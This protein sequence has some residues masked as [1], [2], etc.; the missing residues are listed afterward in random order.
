MAAAV[1]TKS[2]GT[3]KWFR[4]DINGLR[5]LAIVPVVAFHAGVPGVPGGFTGVDI[6]Y[7]ISGYL[8]TAILLKEAAATG[9][10]RIGAFW[11]KRFRR[12]APA[13]CLMVVVTL[14][15]ALPV[16]SPMEWADVSKQS[17]ASVLYVSNMLYAWQAADY[18]A[19]D[20][21]QS[22]LLHTWSL[23]VEEQFYVL[24]PALI[25]LACMIARRFGAPLRTLVI[26]AFGA[27]LVASFAASLWM[28]DELPL[29]AFFGLPSRIWEFAA[30]GLVAALPVAKLFE[31][32]RV[33]LA[34]TVAGLG[35][36]VYGFASVTEFDPFP[37]TAALI[38][39]CG[40]LL[41][42]AGGAGSHSNGNIA[43]RA[44]SA[45]PVQWI[46]AVSYS[47]YLWHWP[48]IVLASAAFQ[49]P[50]VWIKLGAGAA[51][52]FV[53][54]LSYRYVE[55]PIRY[56]VRLSS[57]KVRTFA[58]TA[59]AAAGVCLASTTVYVVSPV[60][61]EKAFPTLAA[62][63]GEVLDSDDC[64]AP[65]VSPSGYEY[66]L[67]GDAQGSRSVLVVGDSHAGQWQTA[68]GVAA[69]QSGVRLM[70]RWRSSCPAIPVVVM[71]TRNVR[72]PECRTFQSESTAL[73]EELRPHG[74]IISQATA[75]SGR[76][77]DDDGAVIPLAA[78]L[79]SWRSQYDG[80]LARLE[81]LHLPVAVIEDNPRMGYDPILCMTRWGNSVADCEPSRSAGVGQIKV[82][83]D[84]GAGVIDDH[85][86]V[87]VFSTVDTICGPR[88]C[89][90]MDEGVSI[91]RDSNHLSAVWTESQVPEL[92]ALLQRL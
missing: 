16:T 84:V 23:G 8:I 53:A 28:T 62:V 78:Q 29:W 24:W 6:F 22:P 88:T 86:V 60:V 32:V 11:A 63:R 41:V 66:C 44:L 45:R 5:A 59:A 89:S 57:S 46:G 26:G 54:A 43:C 79:E 64:T 70:V 47:W 42:I 80:Y 48:C 18:F 87:D 81:T 50:S 21:N 2:S 74:V 68:L 9:R 36:I 35:L 37:G 58:F 12:L 25:V 7:V 1:L 76:I 15:V 75:Y 27:A 49:S 19:A 17:A 56:N 30:G 73:M 72:D 82:L 55:N 90:L 14:V 34:A 38:P 33:A 13:L 40:T 77:L 67:L 52:L 10:V 92:T 20:L 4:A 85:D 51:S 91:F 3:A 69:Q 65:A 71:N 39:T 83:Q 61:V 31:G